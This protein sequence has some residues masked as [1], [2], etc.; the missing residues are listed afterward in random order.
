ME[1]LY[2]KVELEDAAVMLLPVLEDPISGHHS[3]ALPPPILINNEEEYEVEEILDSRIF[4]GKT[5][6]K[7]K[8]RDMA[9]RTSLE[10]HKPILI[11]FHAD[12][13][14]K[15]HAK[16]LKVLPSTTSHKM[17]SKATLALLTQ[18]NAALDAMAL[19]ED[20]IVWI[21]YLFQWRDVAVIF[22]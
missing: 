8:G 13:E 15:P 19:A 3:K 20:D 7:V 21:A 22:V 4:W 12:P 1:W 17:G 16:K 2:L 6:F 10:I 11:L 14:S 5:Q 18:V 9:S